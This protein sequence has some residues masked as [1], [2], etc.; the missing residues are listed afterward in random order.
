M[1]SGQICVV[2]SMS[3]SQDRALAFIENV[4]PINSAQW[5]IELKVDGNATDK[6]IH[7]RLDMNN[8]S[9]SNSCEVL[10]Y[11]LGSM[12][13]TSDSLEVILIIRENNFYQGIVNIDNA[14]SY[15]RFGGQIEVANITNFLANYQSWS[16]FDST[17]M[18][19]TLSNVEIAQNTSI[20]S[21]NLKMSINHTNASTVVHWVFQDSGRFNVSFE[22]NFPVSFYDE[23]Q[24][25][26]NIPTLTP[27]VP[28]LSLLTVIPLVVLMFSI[29]GLLRHRK[30]DV[31]SK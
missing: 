25:S 28:E 9:V 24:I 21:E 12:V 13:G 10:I 18:I 6:Q 20:S 5:R 29:A 8:I 19:E 26:S 22:N 31:L 27:T 11:F 30:P 4:L 15:N 3:S 2:R 14:P 7:E 17:K 16:G 1:A 23:R